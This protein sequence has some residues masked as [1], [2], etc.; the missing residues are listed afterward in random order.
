MRHLFTQVAGESHRN[1][2]GS[3]RQAIIQHCRVGEL[4]ALEHEPDNSHDINAIRVLR[5]SREQIGYL[6]RDFA[7]EV[8]S[9]SAK[10]WRF[11]AVVAGVGRAGGAGPYGVALLI[12][13]EKEVANDG[14]V[15]GYARQILAEEVGAGVLPVATIER[16]SR[17]P[18]KPPQDDPW[19]GWRWLLIGAF[20]LLALIVAIGWLLLVTRPGN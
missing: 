6:T 7:G 3:D 12:V 17:Q 1:A 2:D 8:V 19:T 4:L 20:S 16:S 14:E 9:R 11:H 18:S 5:R 13:V 15:L 10:G